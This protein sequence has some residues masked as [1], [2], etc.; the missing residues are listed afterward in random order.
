MKPDGLPP[1][2][3]AAQPNRF[4]VKRIAHGTDQ[5]YWVAANPATM[6]GQVFAR[7]KKNGPD[8]SYAD[9]WA[10][11]QNRKIQEREQKR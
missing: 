7:D 6:Q 5:F 10:I 9:Q 4:S 3:L 11:E 2:I 1:E 8:T